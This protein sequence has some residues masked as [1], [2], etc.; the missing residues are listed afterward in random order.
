MVSFC[1][2]NRSEIHESHFLQQVLLGYTTMNEKLNSLKRRNGFKFA[3]FL[4]FFKTAS[5]LTVPFWNCTVIFPYV[6]FP[7]GYRCK[8][9]EKEANC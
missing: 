4:K 5:L 1:L 9:F 2:Y 6:F 3:Y 8:R 7:L